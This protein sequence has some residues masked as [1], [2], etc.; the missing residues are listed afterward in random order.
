MYVP[1]GKKTKP[2]F[3]TLT[4]EFDSAPAATGPTFP[5]A[6]DVQLG[7]VVDTS[8]VNPWP[9]RSTVDTLR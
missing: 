6:L 2:E 5:V 4:G 7:P 9:T 1:D 8:L 3:E